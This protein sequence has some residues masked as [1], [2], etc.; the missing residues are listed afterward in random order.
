[1]KNNFQIGDVVRN[2]DSSPLMT[3]IG[4]P[5]SLGLYDAEC[6]W[7][8][9]EKHDFV[10]DTFPIQCLQFVRHN[11]VYTNLQIGDVVQLASGSPQLTVCRLGKSSPI[12]NNP[13]IL[14]PSSP[15]LNEVEC[16]WWDD[17]KHNFANN[18][19][20]IP[21]LQFI[22]HRKPINLHLNDVVKLTSGSPYFTITSIYN[23]E[24][25]LVEVQYP[26]KSHNDFDMN[27]FE[28]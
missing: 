10:S 17:E 28:K 24:L 8:D 5:P 1:M 4:L 11:V 18:I 15:G 23:G 7:W 20:P 21:C 12:Y 27:L 14:M 25:S 16:I 3:I 9:D 6:I 13:N 22:R 26:E 19:F 2:S